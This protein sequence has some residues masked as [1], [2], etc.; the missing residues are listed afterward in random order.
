MMQL[1]LAYLF[2]AGLIAAVALLA[3]RNRNQGWRR[4]RGAWLEDQAEAAMRS[5]ESPWAD[6]PLQHLGDLGRLNRSLTA[7][8]LPQSPAVA[9][10]PLKS[11]VLA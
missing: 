11:N 5:L 9:E 3:L 1:S 2:A 6:A 4:R 7:Y 8:G 10:K